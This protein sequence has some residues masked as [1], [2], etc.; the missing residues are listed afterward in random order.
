MKQKIQLTVCLLLL[1]LGTVM[2]QVRTIKGVVTDE[3][4][5]PL[6]GVAVL[7]KGTTMGTQTD[8]DG[9]YEISTRVGSMLEF[10]Y[11]GYRNE[12]VL[13][14]KQ[15]NLY[16]KLKD[17][18]YICSHPIF[19]VVKTPIALGIKHIKESLPYQLSQVEQIDLNR[20]K[21]T[22]VISRLSNKVAG[23]QIQIPAT[24]IGE[25][26]AVLRGEQSILGNNNVLYVID[27]MPTYNPSDLNPDDIESVSVLSGAGASL[28][29]A[30]AA[31]GVMLINTKNGKEGYGNRIQISS[32]LTFNN[33]LLLTE[34]QDTYSNAIGQYTSWGNKMTTPS[35]HK[36]NSFFRTGYVAQNT[37]SYRTG[38]S[39]DHTYLSASSLRTQGVLPNSVYNR[40]NLFYHSVG[41]FLIDDLFLDIT[42]AY[43]K[44]YERNQKA[45]GLEFN[46]I[47]GLYLYPRGEQFAQEEA[48]ER[49][50]SA[51]GYAKQ[52]WYAGAGTT[53]NPTD[54]GAGIQNPYWIAYRNLRHNSKDRMMASVKL[55]YKTGD[56]FDISTSIKAD[57]TQWKGEDKRFASTLP[58]YAGINGYYGTSNGNLKHIYAD[59]IAQYRGHIW[60]FKNS[61]HFNLL[62]G[63]SHEQYKHLWE[64]YSGNL[65]QPNQFDYSNINHTESIATNNTNDNLYQNFA[66]FM[67]GELEWNYHS[68][69]ATVRS[70]F[71]SQLIY[72]NNAPIISYSVGVHAFLN[73]LFVFVLDS[74]TAL[75]SLDMIANYSQIAAPIH[76]KGWGKQVYL[77]QE[78]QREQTQ[79]CE[80]GFRTRWFNK[81]LLFDTTFYRSLTSN[82]LVITPLSTA[83]YTQQWT[84]A[85]KVENKGVE[86]KLS[87]LLNTYINNEYIMNK[88]GLVAAYNQRSVHNYP[89]SLEFDNNPKW[90][91]GL[92]GN[93]SWRT[94]TL[95][96]LVSARLGGKVLSDTERYLDQYGVSKASG[97]VRDAGQG[98]SALNSDYLYSASN[99]RLQE[100]SLT[101][102]LNTKRLKG[103]EEFNISLVGNNLLMLYNKAPF[104]PEIIPSAE[105]RSGYDLFML[106]SL[107]SYGLNVNI[108]F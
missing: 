16:I 62:G 56:N 37:I 33:P 105:A 96:A 25:V 66:A 71:P 14:G 98:F 12:S 50:D 73:H 44:G 83:P 7:I 104:D 61:F 47:V 102:K 88:I 29:G 46:P 65:L 1:F 15:K 106:P 26:R 10:S 90:L 42:T 41:K 53:D 76:Y 17:S 92:N 34:F 9:K 52:Y 57:K 28:Y 39:D 80:V 45:D 94:L 20:V 5:L 23:L 67:Q 99:V 13:V 68:L 85:G 60:A 49:Y 95:D 75:S 48:F 72:Q 2:A 79:L 59:A 97:V 8:I 77:P 11:L 81:H 84:Q 63:V 101:Y 22:N 91:L 27:G 21:Q 30:S 36:I 58:S 32:S 64:S 103:L 93:I 18:D 31:N 55:T 24:G 38:N 74:T 40:Y 78:L 100:V 3:K 82:Q 43:T 70:D 69:T 6:F 87:Y 54:M 86:M 4:G 19:T 108:L 51:L 35:Q 89:N 107:R